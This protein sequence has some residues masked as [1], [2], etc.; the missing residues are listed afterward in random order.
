MSFIYLNYYW[1]D[2]WIDTFLQ[3]EAANGEEP[4]DIEKENDLNEEKV[5]EKDTEKAK[6][7]EEIKKETADVAEGDNAVETKKK[8][9]LHS[10][11]TLRG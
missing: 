2:L 11:D 4:K 5:Q 8:K 9:R 6:D 10:L 1:L 3:A 7:I